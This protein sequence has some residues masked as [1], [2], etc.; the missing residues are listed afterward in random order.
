MSSRREPSIQPMRV[1]DELSGKSLDAVVRA[2]FSL[3]WGKARSC[4]ETG[5]VQL[6]GQTVTQGTRRV[7]A[8]S[9]VALRMSAPRPRPGDLESARVV[10]IDTHVVVVNKPAGIST[11]PY[12]EE[13]DPDTLDAKVRA[14]LAR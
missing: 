6:D 1:S 14:L 7:R 12:G 3:T 10:F 2:L 4:I 9:E 8:G 13:E 5:K 11:I